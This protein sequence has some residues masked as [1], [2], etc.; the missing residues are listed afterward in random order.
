MDN[1]NSKEEL[2]IYY[3]VDTEVM[4]TL[5]Y[6]GR[7]KGKVMAIALYTIMDTPLV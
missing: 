2:I 6:K 1:R 4:K 3:I 7:C 5:L